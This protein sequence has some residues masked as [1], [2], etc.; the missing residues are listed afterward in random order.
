MTH[1][2]KQ[3]Y[4]LYTATDACMLLRVNGSDYHRIIQVRLQIKSCESH[5]DRVWFLAKLVDT[6][7]DILG[8]SSRTHMQTCKKNQTEEKQRTVRSCSLLYAVSP[9]ILNRL[10]EVLTFEEIQKD[11]SE[12]A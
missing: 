9:S 2:L 1:L 7:Q 8:S 3:V 12:S 4:P 5:T 10:A 11:T 6:L